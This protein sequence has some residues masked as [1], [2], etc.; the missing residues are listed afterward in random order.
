MVVVQRMVVGHQTM[1]QVVHWEGGHVT[2]GGGGEGNAAIEGG[3][4]LMVWGGVR[5]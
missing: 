2:P 4:K 3:F 1:L 5:R